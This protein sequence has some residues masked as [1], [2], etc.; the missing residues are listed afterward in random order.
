MPAHS[1]SRK[2]TPNSS[3]EKE[4]VFRYHWDQGKAKFEE[5][6]LFHHRNS[7]FPERR[8]PHFDIPEFSKSLE[9]KSAP[10]PASKPGSLCI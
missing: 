3:G 1:V 6:V 8:V 10:W 9:Q 5:A 7:F 4:R 2:G